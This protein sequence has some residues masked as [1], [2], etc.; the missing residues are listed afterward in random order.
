MNE[1]RRQ[2][3]YQR[4]YYDLD[5]PGSFSTAKALYPIAKAQDSSVTLKEIE[6]WLSRQP[7]YSINKQ[8]KKT[9]RR[10]KIITRGMDYL[11]QMD[12]LDVTDLA[13]Y[14]GN[15]RYLLVIIDCFSRFVMISPLKRKTGSHVAQAIDNLYKRSER[16]PERVQSDLGGEFLAPEV[17]T[18]WKK[19]NIK[20]YYVASSKKSAIVERFNKFFR[21]ILGK[22]VAEHP[23]YLE[24][25]PSLID[26]YNSRKHSSI[27]IAPKEVNKHNEKAIWRRQYADYLSVRVPRK[28]RVGDVVK[29]TRKK[30]I[31]RKEWKPTWTAENYIIAYVHSTAPAT[32]KVRAKTGVMLPGSYY[33]SQLL[34]IW[35][36]GRGDGKWQ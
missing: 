33:E 4:I 2:R 18:L 26:W 35:M 25:L 3:L 30:N 9:F 36:N 32:Y 6:K 34:K 10:R 5:S 24:K 17:K 19:Y 27:G 8:R 29:L 21:R 22:A 11:Q 31:F 15:I 1:R 14:N 20:W 13:R 12:L 16:I 23:R 7:N 28:F